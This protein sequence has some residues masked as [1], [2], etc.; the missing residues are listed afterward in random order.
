MIS[1]QGGAPQRTACRDFSD[2]N[3]QTTHTKKKHIVIEFS[4]THNLN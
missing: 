2:K 4:N 3:E 1:L